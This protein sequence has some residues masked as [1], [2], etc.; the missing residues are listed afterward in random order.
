[1]I[2]R[3]LVAIAAFHQDVDLDPPTRYQLV[4]RTITDIRRTLKT[5]PAPKDPLRTEHLRRAIERIP[6]TL[7]G[8]RDR[9]FAARRLRRRHAP[10]GAG[11]AAAHARRPQSE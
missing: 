4:W 6:D 10:L 9:A 8:M 5:W 11:G 1:M 3:R 2:E 7:V